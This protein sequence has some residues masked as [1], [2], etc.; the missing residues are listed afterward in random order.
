MALMTTSEVTSIP[1]ERQATKMANRYSMRKASMKK[2]RHEN[3]DRSCHHM[4]ANIRY[5]DDYYLL[6]TTP[7][8]A[9]YYEYYE[10][11]SDIALW[12]PLRLTW[13]EALTGLATN[14]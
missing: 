10:L 5:I 6:R 7:S 12:H 13:P 2:S 3:R 8:C 14:S 4:R 9:L 11:S 1:Y